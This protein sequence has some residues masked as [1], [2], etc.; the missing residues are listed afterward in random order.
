VPPRTS[1]G[2]SSGGS[3]TVESPGAELRD[4]EEH[5]VGGI[6]G[7]GAIVPVAAVEVGATRRRAGL[8]IGAWLA[9][10]WLGMLLAVSI[11][12]PVLPFGD[13]KATIRLE[14]PCPT[15]ERLGREVEQC[16]IQGKGPLSV[17]GTARG[18]PLGGD[19]IGR[20]MA[21]RL[22]YGA[23]TSVVV[24]IG[25]VAVGFVI[26]GVVGLIAGYFGGK[27]DT[28]LSGIM[29][30]LLSLP[31]IVLALA[32]VAFLQ[33]PSSE[34][35]GGNAL[36]SEVVLIIAI[37]VVAIPL[38]GR[39][40]RGSTISWAQ[41]EFV[42]AARAQG[43]KNFR[44]MFREVLPN[45]LPAMFSV[46]L[47]GIAVAMVAEGALSILGLGVRPPGAS[48]GNILASGRGS[49]EDSPHIVLE[50]SILIFVTVLALNYLG[51]VVRA[52]FDV[53]EAGI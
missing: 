20:S 42:L 21:A 39:I 22:A 7:D 43:A 41:R 33:P 28:V 14:R 8:G 35:G 30:V 32:L 2:P 53:R 23:R 44:I 52:R 26:G 19:T 47:L 12:V 25:A 29:N 31:A 34:A 45:V 3:S 10:G 11:L 6:E 40:T 50:P 9:I 37:G 13:P 27:L 24:A 38:L 5:D 51:D 46:A 16:T 1:P 15:V 49:L 48:W 18:Y 17:D 36:P 4:A